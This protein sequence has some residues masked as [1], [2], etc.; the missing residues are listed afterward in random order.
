MIRARVKRWTATTAMASLIALQAF[1]GSAAAAVPLATATSAAIPA[2]YSAGN[3]AGFRGTYVY[4]DG[5]TLAKLILKIE[6]TDAAS[7]AYVGATVNGSVVA[8]ACGTALPVVCTFRQVRMNDRII[9][10]AAFTPAVGATSV[11]AKFTWSS[12]GSTDSD[13]GTSHGDTWSDAAKT[14]TLSSDP[15]YAGG[16]VTGSA[17]SIQNLQAVSAGNPQATGLASL[18]TGV[19]ATVFDGA[20]AT[21]DCINTATVDCGNAF[22]EWSEVTVGDGE[23]FT[24]AFK[25]T[26]T[27]YSG[28]PKGF[29]HSYGDPVQ[30]EFIG[31]CPKKNPASGAPCFTW[32]AKTNTATIYTFHNG[33]YRGLS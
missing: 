14:A 20:L 33:S 31:A 21:G 29:V 11:T 18:P 24:T 2:Q 9:V 30:Q 3:A 23:T 1:A 10:A 8:K 5:S 27:Y 28:T 4:G 17:T 7:V 12:T 16:F 15:D 26:I 32:S 13:G 6:T 25:V 19:A 22:G